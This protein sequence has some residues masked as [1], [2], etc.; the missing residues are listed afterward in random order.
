MSPQISSTEVFQRYIKSK[1]WAKNY[2]EGVPL[3]SK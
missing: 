1:I 2:D 3:R